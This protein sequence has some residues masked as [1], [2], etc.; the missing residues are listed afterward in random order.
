[1]SS[2]ITSH[3]AVHP[4]IP[5]S[6]FQLCSSALGSA[7]VGVPINCLAT[8]AGCA[9]DWRGWTS[10]AFKIVLPSAYFVMSW[11]STGGPNMLAVWFWL[12]VYL[13]MSCLR[14]I[15]R[16]HLQSAK[17]ATETTLSMTSHTLDILNINKI[18][19]QTISKFRHSSVKHQSLPCNT[20]TN[21]LAIF[22]LQIGCIFN[23]KNL[24]SIG[25]SC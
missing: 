11:D 7:E 5:Q 6:H 14:F 17:A 12:S 19:G 10:M 13:P 9:S 25:V 24:G 22:P 21:S 3:K 18:K 20:L 8:R 23:L 2:R 16:F 1:M 4:T 15:M